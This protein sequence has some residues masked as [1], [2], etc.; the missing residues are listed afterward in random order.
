MR[1]PVFFVLVLFC[2]FSF[3]QIKNISNINCFQGQETVRISDNNLT[4]L[5]Y[6]EKER[7]LKKPVIYSVSLMTINIILL[8]ATSYSDHNPSFDQF[9]QA[10]TR[11]P[12]YDDD[13]WAINYI[14]HP[15][16]GSETYLRA[17]EGNFGRFG[18]FMFSTAM[19]LTWEFIIESWTERPSIQ[20]LLVTSTTGSILGELRYYFK[21]K[22]CSKYHWF[23][24]PINTIYLKI[25]S[26]GEKKKSISFGII[27]DI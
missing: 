20:D 12:V 26:S 25:S 7:D 19:S 24:D 21:N 8:V 10:F 11:P 17:R 15:I 6:K 1:K 2:S 5:T 18:S 23:I 22:M 13:H 9:K 14:S 27:V 16:M 3:A 4:N